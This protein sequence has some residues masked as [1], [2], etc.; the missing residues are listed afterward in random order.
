[1]RPHI[2][3]AF[4][5]ANSAEKGK[6]HALSALLN[7]LNPAAQIDKIFYNLKVSLIFCGLNDIDRLNFMTISA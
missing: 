4:T 5:I 1:M 3:D 6:K 2:D 7:F